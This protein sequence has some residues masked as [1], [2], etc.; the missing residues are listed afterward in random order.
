MRKYPLLVAGNWKMNGLRANLSEIEALKAGVGSNETVGLWVF[1]PATLIESAA[2]LASGSQLKVGG[3][4]CRAEESGAFTGDISAGMLKDAGASAVIVGH[5][6][7]RSLHGE[8][9]A[10]VRAK[11]AAALKHGL[12]VIVCLGETKGEREAGLAPAVCT[13]QLRESLPQKS[14]PDN[15]I[16]AYEPVWAIGTGLSPTAADISAIHATIRAELERR[17]TSETAWRILYGGSVTSANAA[18]IFESPE[19]DGVLVGGASL[20][21]ASFLAI[22]AAASDAQRRR[23]NQG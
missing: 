13:R 4:D 9:S 6:E 2:S 12:D 14:T 5:S 17:G 1:P 3:Q 18:A 10:E 16:V 20:N 23:A 21:A 11:A 8:T 15:T 7:R 19:T 22:I